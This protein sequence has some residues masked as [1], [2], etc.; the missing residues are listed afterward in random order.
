MRYLLDTNALSDH[1]RERSRSLSA[2]MR[3]HS[4]EQLAISAL[5]IHEIELGVL[6][7]ERQDRAAGARLRSWLEDQVLENFAA[8]ILPVDEQVVR[9]A[10]AFHIPD[11]M[12]EFD[13]LIAAT[14]IRHDLT[15]V[16]RNRSDMDRT[17][18]RLL[19]PWER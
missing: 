11:P 15:L 19:S 4:Y 3:R 8:N 2:W 9:I 10:A 14:A 12:P 1:R 5:T 6:R 16:T 17:G 13:A 18:V 7:L